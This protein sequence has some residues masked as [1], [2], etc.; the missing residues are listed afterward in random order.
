MNLKLVLCFSFYKEL[1]IYITGYLLKYGIL[2]PKLIKI[3][4]GLT[5]L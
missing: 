4:R 2:V 3:D 1:G 5:K